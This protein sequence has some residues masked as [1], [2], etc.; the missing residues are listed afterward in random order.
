MNNR[1]RTINNESS[2]NYNRSSQITTTMVN[3]DTTEVWNDVPNYNNNNNNNNYNYQQKSS[4]E[5]DEFLPL[6][7][8]LFHKEELSNFPIYDNILI[9]WWISPHQFYTHNQNRL[10]LLEKMMKDMQLFYKNKPSITSSTSPKRNNQNNIL[11]INTD[12]IVRHRSDKLFYRARIM[13]YNQK[14]HK[15]K[16]ELIDFGN[17]IIIDDDNIWSVEKKFTELPAMAYQCSFD[18]IISNL[19]QEKSL[20][21]IEKYIK[22]GTILQCEYIR[23]H[24][25]NDCYFVEIKWENQNLKD[26]L[27]QDGIISLVD[28]GMHFN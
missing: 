5:S 26:L 19:N 2:T 3:D 27:I 20:K 28:S 16:V 24:E 18:G 17:Q 7:P 12:L 4:F 23:K 15:Y 11:D 8:H 25:E 22:P 10:K 6:T 21:Y 13:A 1:Q 14:I 9:S